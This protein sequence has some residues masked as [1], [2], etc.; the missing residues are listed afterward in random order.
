MKKLVLVGGGHAHLFVLKQ[1]SEQQRVDVEITLITP[2]PF[3]IYSGMLPGWMAGHYPLEDIQI[4]LRPWVKAAN[5]NLVLDAIVEIDV[6][7]CCVRLS[8]GR[9]V[10]YDLLS[11]DTGSETDISGLG[12]LGKKLLPVKP[13]IDFVGIWP[14]LLTEIQKKPDYVL[15]VVGGGA[16]SVE[17]ALAAHF[18]MQNVNPQAKVYLVFSETG[19][20]ASH[21]AKVRQRITERMQRVGVQLISHRAVGVEKGVF[22]SNGD[23]VVADVVIAATGAQ[24][25]Y[26]LATSGLKLGADGFIAVDA[27]QRSV[28][29][30][31]V[32]ATGDVCSRQDVSVTRSGV[33][34]VHAGPVLA[35][36]LLAALSKGALQSYQPRSSPLYLISCGEQYAVASWGKFSYQ[37]SW[38]WRW[39]DYID[40]GFVRRFSRTL[41]ESSGSK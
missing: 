10:P 39:K 17:L 26:W 31:N 19:L 41:K 24:P 37:G 6:E 11:L 35:N 30:A 22:L 14:R 3:Q 33:H 2:E 25:A 36:N 34:A 1:L 32:F 7:N 4:D 29:H 5:A 15:V 12:L 9:V 28:S 16:A 8:S 40:R 13:F 20:L 27:F 38:V 23:T 21:P 18:S